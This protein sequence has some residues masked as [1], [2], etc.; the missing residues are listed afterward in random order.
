M[1]QF[2]AA[3]QLRTAFSDQCLRLASEIEHALWFEK[4]VRMG[5]CLLTQRFQS[6][7]NV[8]HRLTIRQMAQQIQRTG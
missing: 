5:W 3:L 2:H 4:T 6:T 8:C 7:V 1:G